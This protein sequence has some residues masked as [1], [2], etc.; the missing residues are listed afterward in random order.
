[1]AHWDGKQIVYGEPSQC[2]DY[3]K[4][5]VVDCGCCVGV[6]W[7]G[8]YPIECDRCG[9]SGWIYHHRKSGLLSQY[10]GGPFCGKICKQQAVK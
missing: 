1:M 9:G 7:G 10:P 3:P 2:K 5:D 4:W 6:K 8:E